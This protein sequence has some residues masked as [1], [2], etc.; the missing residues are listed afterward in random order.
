MSATIA[1][2]ASQPGSIGDSKSFLYSDK[3]AAKGY[4]SL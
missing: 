1:L 2:G 3:K 4:S